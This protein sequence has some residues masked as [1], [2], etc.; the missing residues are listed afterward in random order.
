[1]S[2]CK[3]RRHLSLR[4]NTAANAAVTSHL[5]FVYRYGPRVLAKHTDNREMMLALGV[6]VGV[7]DV[8]VV[9]VVVIDVVVGGVRRNTGKHLR[10][11]SEKKN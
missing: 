5:L 10:V 11:S 4:H 8:V 3:F 9:G 6:G 7:V 1:M 2:V